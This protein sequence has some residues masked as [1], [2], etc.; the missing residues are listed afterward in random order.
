MPADNTQQK[1]FNCLPAVCLSTAYLPPAEY[2]A[3]WM[4]AG[5]VYLEQ[6]EHFVKQTYRNRCRIATASGMMEL[7]IPVERPDGNRTLIRD[8][9]LANHGNWP[10]QHWKAIESA[11]QSAP[12]FEY[13]ADD[14]EAVY[15]KPGV[16]LWDFNEK[17][18]QL[19]INWIDTLHQPLHTMAYGV[20]PE[21]GVD[22]R[23]L[24]HPKKPA[25]I[26]ETPSYY[27]VFSSKNGYLSH[28][29]ILDLMMNCGNEAILY[30]N[31]FKNRKFSVF[32]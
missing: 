21:D 14:L 2:V 27:Q 4:H 32:L 5:V 31:N 7:S 29:S 8:V 24:I 23:E 18:M 3:I 1:C 30:L 6:H 12:F 26:D 17:M 22:L 19:V 15:K 16:F 11:Y 25:L 20:F 10:H 13:L 9:R 28:L